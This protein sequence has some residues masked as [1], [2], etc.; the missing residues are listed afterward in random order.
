MVGAASAVLTAAE[1]LRKSRR[2][3]PVDSA[4]DR[5]PANEFEQCRDT[6]ILVGTGIVTQLGT[7]HS[8]DDD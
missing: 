8:C 5:D 7:L 6:S 3:D 1:R 4:M 2:V